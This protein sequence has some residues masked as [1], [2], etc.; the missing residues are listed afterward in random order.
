MGSDD[1]D[2]INQEEIP[3]HRAHQPT[4]DTITLAHDSNPYESFSQT[5]STDRIPDEQIN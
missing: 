3:Y 2:E 1:E 4:R 5:L